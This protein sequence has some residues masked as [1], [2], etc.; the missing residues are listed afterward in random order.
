VVLRSGRLREANPQLVVVEDSVVRS[1]ENITQNPE[2]A[3]RRRD[4]HSCESTDALGSR[5]ITD[6]QNVLHKQR[7]I[8]FRYR[9]KMAV[10]FWRENERGWLSTKQEHG[11][12]MTMENQSYLLR[13]QRELLAA[14]GERDVRHGLKTG[15]VHR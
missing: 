1:H 3:T 8:K 15:T 13:F 6:L 5:S 14:N 11:E 9:N 12:G 4:I 7:E 2:G 10:V